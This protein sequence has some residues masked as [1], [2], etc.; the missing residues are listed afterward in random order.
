VPGLA[1][2]QAGAGPA[3]VA[4]L[5]PAVAL[6]MLPL[7]SQIAYRPPVGVDPATPLV[8]IAVAGLAALLGVRWWRVSRGSA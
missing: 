8:W 4:A 6:A 3:A 1:S 2:A 7:A 5:V